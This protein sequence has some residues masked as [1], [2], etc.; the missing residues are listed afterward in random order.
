MYYWGIRKNANKVKN[1]VGGKFLADLDWMRTIVN[2]VDG[3][4]LCM[5]SKRLQDLGA[6]NG[7]GR[8][9]WDSGSY[10]MLQGRVLHLSQ[11]T[12]MMGDCRRTLMTLVQK[13]P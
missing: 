5:G 13:A 12:T 6:S 2:P 9:L 3:S 8:G 10:I 7:V 4:V 1:P 11:R